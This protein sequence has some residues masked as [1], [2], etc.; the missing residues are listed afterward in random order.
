LNVQ[1]LE[2]SK[3][4]TEFIFVLVLYLR[5]K[6]KRLVFVIVSFEEKTNIKYASCVY[7]FAKK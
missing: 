1:V 7:L 5:R 2:Y 6:G 4:Q 3:S